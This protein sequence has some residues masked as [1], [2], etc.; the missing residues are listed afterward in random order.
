MPTAR[1]RPGSET[2]KLA[3]WYT[4]YLDVDAIEKAGFAPIKPELDAIAAVANRD[5]LIGLFA[6]NH[7]AL[8]LRPLA[9]GVDFDR[10]VKDTTR[11]TIDIGGLTLGARDFYLDPAYAPVRQLQLAHMGRLLKVAGFDDVEARA[12]RAQD[13]EIK[14]ARIT[15]TS[16]EQRDDLRKNNVITVAELSKQA[17][18]F[19]WPKYLAAT[20]VRCAGE[21][22][23]ADAVV[24][25]GH[26]RA[27]QRGTDRGMAGLHA[28]RGRCRDFEL[29]AEGRAGRDVRVPGQGTARH[30]GAAASLDRRHPRPRR[31]RQAL[32]RSTEQA[33]CQRRWQFGYGVGHEKVAPRRTVECF[34]NL[35]ASNSSTFG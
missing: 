5:Q 34:R 2:R 4:S 33:M 8:G 11:P 19:D 14:I 31:P 17:P 23:P 3:D 10:N 20:G 21:S 1:P 22:D 15:W 24:G 27:G 6:K 35:E 9:I 12:R 28:L 32:V 30:A 25:Q 16:A 29:P 7:G 13:L 26:G 18:G